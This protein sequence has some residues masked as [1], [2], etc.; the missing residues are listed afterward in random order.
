MLLGRGTE[1]ARLDLALADAKGGT[2]AALV[3]RGAAGAGKS[4]LLAHALGRADGMTKLTARG[5]ESESELAFSGL[6]DLLRPVLPRV[7]DLPAP[8]ASALTSALALGPPCRLDRLAVLTGTLSLLTALSD[9]APVLAVVDD[10]QWLDPWSRDALVFVARRL[11]GERVALVFASR[12]GAADPFER[13]DLPEVVLSGLGPRPARQLLA[14]HAGVSIPE[15]VANRIVAATGGNPRALLGVRALLTREQLGGRDP[16]PERLAV[17][18]AGNAAAAARE[19]DEAVAAALEVAGERAR[20]RTSYLAAVRAFERAARLSPASDAPSRRLACAAAAAQAAG[21]PRH[22]LSLL[23]DALACEGDEVGRADLQHRRGDVLTWNGSAREAHTLLVSESGRIEDAHPA[24]AARM[25]VDAVLPACLAGLVGVGIA[26]AAHAKELADRSDDPEIRSLA[27]AVLGHA[28]VLAGEDRSAEAHLRA[29]EP[30][31][32]GILVLSPAVHVLQLS[33]TGLIMLEDYRR[34]RALLQRA[35]DQARTETALNVLPFLLWA[36]SSLAYVTG[37][38]AAAY[39]DC[40]ESVR[41]GEEARQPSPN[42]LAL[43][44]LARLDA[45]QGRERDCRAHAAQALAHADA[46]GNAWAEAD[47]WSAL[48]LL[49]L[50]L[51]RPMEAI[52]HLE[53]TARS[54]TDG[55]LSQAAANGWAPDLVEAYARA[56]R[57]GDAAA[58]LAMLNRYAHQTGRTWSLAVTARCRG[59]LADEEHCERDFEDADAWHARTPTPFERARTALCRAERLRRAGRRI[60]SRA[61]LTGALEVFQRLGATPWAER[62][63]V[64]LAATA[65][66]ARKRGVEDS[67]QLTAQELQVALRVARGTSNREAAAELFLSPKTIEYHLANIYRKLG[68]RS[69]TRLARLVAQGDDRFAPPPPAEPAASHAER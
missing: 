56:G 69:R 58:A 55:G 39:A 27:V 54:G 8:Q 40:W 60:D 61:R 62:S 30:F 35:I 34:A 29:A 68:V 66:V 51:C 28:L 20:T 59:L 2:S 16:L 23:D 9:E 6:A 42:A 32:E 48:A 36:R 47:A 41:L 31:L 38:W 53:P 14:R 12:D 15:G 1:S 45:A 11:H 19:P 22:A 37:D 17:A 5:Y 63:S 44:Q 13:S 33:V 67:K 46:H 21:S 26:T 52:E 7:A 10:A 43:A 64:E 25:L 24:K 65:P 3:V 18:R 4:A 49:E 50:G 57:P